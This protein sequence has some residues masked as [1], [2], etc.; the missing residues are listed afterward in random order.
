MDALVQFIRNAL[1]CIKDLKLFPSTIIHDFNHTNKYLPLPSPVDQTTP[2]ELLISLTQLYACISCTISGFRLITNKGVMKL[3]KL[4]EIADT[5]QDK[6]KD[7]KNKKAS[8]LIRKSIMDEADS[9]LRNTL[10]GI[11]VASIGVSFFW[12]VANSLHITPTGWIGG[13][14]ALIHALTVMEIVLLP[15]LYLMLKDA[16]RSISKAARIRSFVDDFSGKIEKNDGSWLDVE[17]FSLLQGDDWAPFWSEG[18]NVDTKVV[19]KDIEVIESKIKLYTSDNVIIVSDETS[20][21]LQKQAMTCKMEGYREYVYF[22]FNFIAFYG[23]LLGII[24]YYFDKEESQPDFVTS[25]KFGASN[26]IAD[27]TGN[28]AGDLMWTIEPIVI[29]LSPSLFQRVVQRK[30]IKVKSD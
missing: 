9:A 3:R 4:S 19:E 12:L 13:L 8:T 28:F 21:R 22:I 24:V 18:K 20:Q 26:E 14:P 7:I 1:C 6:Y 10:V 16:Y 11:C 30:E 5:M 25:L 17:K 23:Y 15:L 2:L 29:F 27:W